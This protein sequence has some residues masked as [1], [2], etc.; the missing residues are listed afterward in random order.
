[1]NDENWKNLTK[2]NTHKNSTHKCGDL[3]ADNN[4]EAREVELVSQPQLDS[5]KVEKMEL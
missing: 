2:Y 1:M 4:D 3:F 5:V